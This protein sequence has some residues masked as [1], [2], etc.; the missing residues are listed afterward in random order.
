MILHAPELG[1]AQS[2]HTKNTKDESV[3]AFLPLQRLP[4]LKKN[5]SLYYIQFPSSL[6]NTNRI[7][8][9]SRRVVR[10]LPI[11]HERQ[12]ERRTGR[13]KGHRPASAQD[14]LVDGIAADDNSQ[15]WR[16]RKLASEAKARLERKCVRLP[17]DRAGDVLRDLRLV[18]GVG[19]G[20]EDERGATAVGGPVCDDF[21]LHVA[22]EHSGSPGGKTG[23]EAAVLHEAC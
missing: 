1:K 9:H 22:G 21:N 10:A 7:E 2:I 15:Y 20:H 14:D 18:V 6:R 13:R 17:R 23:F 5:A 4:P 19:G 8:H 16:G 3:H 11:E 12:I